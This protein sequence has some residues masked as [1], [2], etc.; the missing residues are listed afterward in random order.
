[1]SLHHINECKS[2][3]VNCTKCMCNAAANDAL[4]SSF[5]VVSR[6]SYLFEIFVE[7]SHDQQVVPGQVMRLKSEPSRPLNIVL[8]FML[9][10]GLNRNGQSC[11]RTKHFAVSFRRQA[12]TRYICFS[13]PF[14]QLILTFCSSV[15]E[16]GYDDSQS[17]KF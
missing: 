3:I 17:N 13:V 6:L 10:I 5:C 1:M 9:A 11:Q 4:L 15:R 12:A 16:K 2:A 14:S 7:I 8:P